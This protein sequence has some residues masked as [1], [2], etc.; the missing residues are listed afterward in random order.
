MAPRRRQR[1]A[2]AVPLAP[3]V[4]LRRFTPDDAPDLHAYLS[5]PAA[6]EFEP[7]GVL[8]ADDAVRTATERAADERFVAVCLASTGRVVGN[9][10]VAPD[11]P[12]QWRTWEIG[13]VF[14]PQDWGK[15]YATEACRALL[16]ELFVDRSAHRVVAHCDP[17][18]TRSWALLERLGFRREAH[19]R[20]AAS[21]AVDDAGRPVWHDAFG[22]GLLADEWERAAV[23]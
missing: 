6:V 17:R 8:S 5:Q 7:Y 12:P 16:Q 3:R 9:L 14:N 22:Y 1:H 11:G 4:V 23:G 21:F 19:L 2:G 13:Y 18:N 15:G 10:Y 20:A